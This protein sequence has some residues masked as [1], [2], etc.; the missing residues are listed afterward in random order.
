MYSYKY[1]CMIL[2]HFNFNFNTDYS[3]F[4]DVEITQVSIKKSQVNIKY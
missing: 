1:A 2:T 3:K 4:T